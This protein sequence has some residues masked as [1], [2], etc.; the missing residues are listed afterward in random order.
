VVL[1]FDGCGTYADHFVGFSSDV[2]L[3]CAKFQCHC[4]MS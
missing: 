4:V 2:A 1:I 3:K